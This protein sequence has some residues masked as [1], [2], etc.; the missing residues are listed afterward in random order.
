MQRLAAL[1]IAAVVSL[2]VFG[3]NAAVIDA[4]FSERE[5]RIIR[6][7]YES[8]TAVEPREHGPEPGRDHGKGRRPGRRSLPPGIAKNLQRGKPLPPGIAKQVLPGDL[9]RALPPAR[10]GHERVIV[11]GRIVLVEAATQ[12]VRDVIADIVLR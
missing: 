10:D 7:Y 8:R 1:V 11:D 5:V 3:S 6:D 12:V 4:V 9:L 2:P